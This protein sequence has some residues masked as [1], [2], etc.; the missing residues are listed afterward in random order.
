MTP[1][2]G[3]NVTLIGMPGSGKSTIGVVL[4][5]RINRQFVD[6]DLVIQTT[7]QRTL[8]QIM[9]SEGFDAFCQIE[10]EAVLSLDVQHHVIATGGSVCYGA[11]GMAHLHRL[12][13]IVFLKTSLATLEKR[14]S[15]MATRGIAL[16]PGQSLEDLFHQR[17][18]LYAK[19]ADITIDCEGLDVERISERIE[20][21]VAE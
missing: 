13:K 18:A 14:L 2:V 3:T 4:A 11:E 10:E 12:G 17:N 1:E 21:A 9:D 16:K 6:T 19:Y 15:N 7:Q 20:V 8:Q 5:K